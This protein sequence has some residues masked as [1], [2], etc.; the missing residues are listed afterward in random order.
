MLS[1]PLTATHIQRRRSSLLEVGVASMQGWRHDHEDYH[2][3]C[4]T[5][6]DEETVQDAAADHGL[7]SFFAV[8]DGHSGDSAAAASSRLLPKNI[9]NSVDAERSASSIVQGF[10]QTDED[11][12]SQNCKSGTTACAAIVSHHVDLFFRS[13]AST[14]L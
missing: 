11:L 3:L 5:W 8:F 7:E 4:C 12:R 9:L 13:V 6:G 2:S 10:I 1:T 14:T